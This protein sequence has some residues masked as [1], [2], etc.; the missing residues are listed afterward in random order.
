[1]TDLTFY[2]YDSLDFAQSALPQEGDRVLYGDLVFVVGAPVR[3]NDG[4]IIQKLTLA[5]DIDGP[6]DTSYEVVP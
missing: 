4:G 1:M 6:V 5:E 3:V 2:E